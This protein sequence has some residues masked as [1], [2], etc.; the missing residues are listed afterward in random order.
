[1]DYHTGSSAKTLRVMHHGTEAHFGDDD[2]N[3]SISTRG[4]API[5][6]IQLAIDDPLR[7]RSQCAHMCYDMM[8]Q[9]VVGDDD[10]VLRQVYV[11]AR[12]SS[13]TSRLVKLQ[14]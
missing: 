7:S 4:R 6:V 2:A 11:L 14:T 1:M 3:A 12:P 5:A 10:R 9:H 13:G 8:K